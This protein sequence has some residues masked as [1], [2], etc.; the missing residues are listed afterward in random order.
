MCNDRKTVIN[1]DQICDGVDDCPV[2][3]N[4][5]YLVAEDETH[6]CPGDCFCLPLKGGLCNKIN[7]N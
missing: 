5:R 6:M 4:S 7:I 1:K 3:N 2:T